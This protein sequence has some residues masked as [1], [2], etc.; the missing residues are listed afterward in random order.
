[1]TV[2]ERER[3]RE[4]KWIVWEAQ[5]LYPFPC[6]LMY[7][8]TWVP[9][10]GW[11]GKSNTI[12]W[13]SH[14]VSQ[15]EREVGRERSRETEKHVLRRWSSHS[16]SLGFSFLVY[17]IECNVYFLDEALSCHLIRFFFS[18]FL[19]GSFSSRILFLSFS[20]RR[21]S[22]FFSVSSLY[23]L[24]ILFPDSF[25]LYLPCIFPVSSL[26]PFLASILLKPKHM[27]FEQQKRKRRIF[28]CKWFVRIPCRWWWCPHVSWKAVLFYCVQYNFCCWESISKRLHSRR[29][30]LAKQGRRGEGR[31]TLKNLLLPSELE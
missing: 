24:C 9:K 21:S 13:W 11:R 1:M 22:I 27:E 7:K 30:F 26:Y 18:F 14:V 15:E 2:K 31:G 4:N 29:Q 19:L 25:S 5:A 20:W 23:P 17:F 10:K 3:E 16:Q 28:E 12:W 6:L 8:K